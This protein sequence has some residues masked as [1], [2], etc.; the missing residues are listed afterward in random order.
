MVVEAERQWPRVVPLTGAGNF[1]DFGGYAV[2]DGGTV[3]RGFLY[4]SNR[5]S[6]L[7]ADD[8]AR[9]DMLGIRAIFDLRARREREGDP[10]V[11]TGDHLATYTFPPGHKRRL[12][13]MA[14]DYSPTPEGARQLM[15]DF[16]AELPRTMAHMVSAIVHRIASDRVPC[17]VHCSAGKDRTGIVAALV[18]ALLGVNR[19]TILADYV[20]TASLNATEE[21]MARSVVQSAVKS[22]FQDRYSADTIAVMRSARPEFLGASLAAIDSDHGSFDA[23]FDAIGVEEETRAALRALL[24]EK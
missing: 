18:L 2:A 10:T 9:L 16:Y 17:V 19:E 3:R 24:I 21:D 20:L 7:T 13:D 4:R 1:R 14:L 22:E 11:W 12:V 23:Y 6:Q 8:I 15:H 5:L